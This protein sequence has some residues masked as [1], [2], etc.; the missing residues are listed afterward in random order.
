MRVNMK[1]KAVTDRIELY[2]CPVCSESTEKPDLNE[3]AKS[4]E[5]GLSQP[6]IKDILLEDEEFSP[7]TQ[8]LK[9]DQLQVDEKLTTQIQNLAKFYSYE[10]GYDTN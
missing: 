5:T 3:K 2:K 7:I 1:K 8:F 9:E 6:F 4:E 10:N